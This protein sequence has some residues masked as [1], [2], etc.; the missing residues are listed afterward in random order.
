MKLQLSFASVLEKI[1]FPKAHDTK[2]SLTNRKQWRSSRF[3][4]AVTGEKVPKPPGTTDGGHLQVE[5]RQEVTQ[6]RDD[7]SFPGAYAKC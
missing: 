5:G 2:P 6:L 3:W 7:S 4:F 1:T